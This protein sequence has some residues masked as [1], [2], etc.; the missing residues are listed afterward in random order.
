MQLENFPGQTLPM[1]LEAL[2]I[3]AFVLLGPGNPIELHSSSSNTLKYRHMQTLVWVHNE[4][5]CGGF[6]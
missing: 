3:A 1:L 4:E 5:A 6:S 2:W